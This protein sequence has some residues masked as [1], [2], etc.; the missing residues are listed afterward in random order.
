MVYEFVI[1]GFR[2]I[3]VHYP[4]KNRPQPPRLT[5]APALAAPPPLSRRSPGR[6]PRRHRPLAGR[7]PPCG[8][9]LPSHPPPPHGGAGPIPGG[10]G[11]WP[12]APRPTGGAR[13]RPRPGPST[14]AT[15]LPRSGTGEPWPHPPNKKSHPR[16]GAAL[17]A[18][19]QS[20]HNSY[21]SS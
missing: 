20:T 17:L 2:P 13:Q 16:K 9:G 12:A 1:S 5:A 4:Q 14:S 3:F 11:R 21:L 19:H 10:I 18:L 15:K 7:P 8:R 6:L